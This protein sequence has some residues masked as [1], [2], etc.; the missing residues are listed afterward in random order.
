MTTATV[1]KSY[2]LPSATVTDNND[3][4][5]PVYVFIM[6]PDGEQRANVADDYSFTPTLRGEY[7]ITYYTCDSYNCY[8]YVEYIIKVM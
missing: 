5:L 7:I 3:A 8:T 1:G 4:S 6:A 2:T